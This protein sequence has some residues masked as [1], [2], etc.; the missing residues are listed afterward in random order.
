MEKDIVEKIEQA[1]LVGR[2][3][4]GYP[5]AKKWREVAS[6]KSNEKYV[7]CNASEGE[8]G[9]FK[10]IYILENHPESVVKGVVLALEYLKAKEAFFNIDRNYYHR[11]G[12][13]LSDLTH[14][15]NH[16]GYKI[17]LYI[18]DPSYIGGEETAL[19]NAIEGNRT[20]PKQK[21]PYPSKKGLFR[22]PT[23]INN[24]ETFYN[25]ACVDNGTFDN[26]R[27]Y[28]ISGDIENPGVYHLPAELKTEEVL[29]ETG[30]YPD[31]EFF[32]Q[33]G[34]SASGEIINQR[35]VKEREVNGA[36][37]VEIYKKN[38]DPKEILLRWFD[39]Y[40]KESCGKCTPCRM[41]S[42]NLYKIVLDSED[43]PWKSLFE[44]LESTEE[45]SFC[46]LGGSIGVPVRSYY[47]NVIKEQ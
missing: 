23:L 19:L 18:K 43:V 13:R 5:T 11:V 41:G 29:K 14:T 6:F 10:D 15:Y 21:P 12:Q 3:G 1:G 47:S 25:V 28:C 7:I 37:G 36:G 35:Q 31:F 24:V 44:I 27:F 34:G 42:Y 46:A 2:G 38:K 39:F 8:I 45:T 26:R 30:N 16:H 40:Q 9:L 20:E 33:I 22:K 32:A 17:E 4:A